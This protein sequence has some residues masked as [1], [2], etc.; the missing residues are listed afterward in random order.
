MD[1][2]L[3]YRLESWQIFQDVYLGLLQKQYQTCAPVGDCTKIIPA[4]AQ[5]LPT[6]NSNGTDFKFTIRKGLKYSNGE[7]VKASDFAHTI[8]RDFNMNSPGIGFFSN[9]VGSAVLRGEPDEVHGHLGDHHERQRR[10]GRDQA[11]QAPV[12][13]RVHP[14]DAVRGDGA[15]LDAQQGHGES[16]S[17]G[18]R[19]VLHLELQA[20][21][22]VRR[23][24]EPALEADP[25]HP[26]RQPEQDRRAR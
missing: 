19:A 22:L 12:R 9:I 20:E 21:P 5:S 18:R 6:V 24:A 23:V 2:G 26:E 14:D 10:H 15:V 1:P 4:I 7:T 17:G 11:D 25:G 13:L 16:A 3:S 8:I